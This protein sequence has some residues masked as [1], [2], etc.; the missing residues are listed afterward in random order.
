[1]YKTNI[2]K[3]ALYLR[4]PTRFRPHPTY[5][6]WHYMLAIMCIYDTAASHC[7]RACMCVHRVSRKPSENSSKRIFP[8]KFQ[9][10]RN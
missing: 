8:E 3:A 7:T 2:V 6:L 1:M 10:L 4:P 5:P 9:A